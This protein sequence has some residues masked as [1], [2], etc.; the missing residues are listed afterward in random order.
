MA[1]E[2]ATRTARRFC[3]FVEQFTQTEATLYTD[4][5]DSYHQLKRFHFPVYQPGDVALYESAVNQKQVFPALISAI[6]RSHQF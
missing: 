1:E 6:V 5:Y 4:K 3:P 2:Q